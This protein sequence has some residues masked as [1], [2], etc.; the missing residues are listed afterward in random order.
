MAFKDN[1]EFIDA[2][3]KTG[4]VVCIKKEVDWDLEAGAITRR[5]CELYG[6]AV[7]FEKIKDYPEGYRIFGGPLATYRRIAVAMG[8]S[9]DTP[10]NEIYDEFERRQEHLYPPWW[11][12]TACV[13]RI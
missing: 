2:L 7:L 13:R 11:P 6:P 3:K 1:R 9:A 10:I 8:L 4:D 12:R 5:A